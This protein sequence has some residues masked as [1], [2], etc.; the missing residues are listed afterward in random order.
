MLTMNGHLKM[1]DSLQSLALSLLLTF[2]STVR[3][4]F[5]HTKLVTLPYISTS[6]KDVFI[7]LICI[8]VQLGAEFVGTLILIFAGTATAIV[9]QKTDGAV[10]LIGCAA[11]AGLAVMI[12][13]LSTGHISG[14]HLNPAITIAFAALKHFPWK[15]VSY[16]Y[17]ISFT[18]FLDVTDKTSVTSI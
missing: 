9:N 15:H 6:T 13:I 12:V 2:P 8:C 4:M 14:A 17:F 5:I 10:T 3:Y 7:L 16:L 18:T 1:E 11:S